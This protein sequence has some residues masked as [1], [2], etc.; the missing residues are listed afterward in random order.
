MIFSN[1]LLLLC[2]LC[3]FF[4]I[5]NTMS[6]T[7]QNGLYEV[8]LTIKSY[9]CKDK[10]VILQVWTR[11]HTENN[12]FF[13]GDANYRFE[14]DPRQIR[15]PRIISQDNFSNVS[16]AVDRNYGTQNLVG[17]TE[18][19]TKAI[20]SLNTFYTGG[21]GGAR[22]VG[23]E[24]AAVSCLE[25]D[26]LDTLNRFNLTWHDDVTFP[27]TGMN[28]V[29][30]ATNTSFNYLLKDVPAAGVFL[31]ISPED[32]Y[33]S[34]C[35]NIQ[36]QIV[37][38]P[39]V[40]NEDGKNTVC[41]PISDANV[42]DKH[43]VSPC[44]LP[45]NGT[46]S[47]TIDNTT[48]TLC[49]T[50]TPNANFFGKDT[51][52][53]NVCDNGNPVLCTKVIV[54][55]TVESQPDTPVV[56]ITPLI[57]AAKSSIEKCMPIADTDLGD[58]FKATLCGVKNG[59]AE[60]TIVNGELCLT[61]KSTQNTEGVDTVC[62]VLCDSYNLCRTVNI[63][64]TITACNDVTP[65]GMACPSNVEISMSGTIINDL[66][67]FVTS[68]KMSDDCDGV[69][70]TFNLPNAEDDCGIRSIKQIS[71]TQ[72]GSVFGVGKN[73]LVF[74]ATDLSGKT[75]TCQVEIFVK[76]I[77]VLTNNTPLAFCQNEQFSMAAVEYPKANYTWTGPKFTINSRVVAFPVI[78]KEQLGVYTV[79]TTFENK[80]A[81]K[82]TVRIGFK[83]APQL[84]D[85]FFAL[86]TDAG[87]KD[88][89]TLNDTLRNIGKYTIKLKKD[90]ATGALTFNE[91][92]TFTYI[93]TAGFT[94]DVSFKYE[95]CYDLCPN[96]CQEATALIKVASRA[97]QA[98]RGTHIITPNN[99]GVND[100]FVIE[101]LDPNSPNNRSELYIY[102]QWGEQVYKANPY[103][104]EWK[105]TYKELP[106]PEGTYYYIFKLNP[107][108]IPKKGFVSILK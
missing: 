106:L 30:I 24:W 15:S 87:L 44:I 33:L 16:N 13:M 101:G 65:P 25:F 1:R 27:I 62:I 4:F 104:N 90:V 42:Q 92:G 5:G 71:G 78:T 6:L 102:S 77:S 57:V 17:S 31:G 43:T 3:V 105:G 21:G 39:I 79:T 40:T 53:L 67:K 88:S 85:D 35:S 86:P 58:T 38:A 70:L 80:C 96:I 95:V 36:P 37:L 72:S 45:T 83:V 52:C 41:A 22:R 97:R 73:T 46:I 10:K 7:A 60:V 93:P 98:V 47:T 51:V 59:T 18:G 76:P 103:K 20:L 84:G 28:E 12:A 89:V 11:A 8:R 55:I 56:A 34:Y 49:M 108:A 94:G 32:T 100:G 14:Y 74:E 82:D 75:T 50:Y 63:P 19:T 99:D 9:A 48:H 64:I 23:T 26:V 91:N 66:S 81:F 61:Y 2:R 54:P 29:I 69:V 107:D 68:S